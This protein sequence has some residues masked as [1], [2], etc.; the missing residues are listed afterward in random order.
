M[1]A[2][3]VALPYSQMVTSHRYLTTAHPVM[4]IG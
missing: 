3:R 4:Q 1:P 2:A